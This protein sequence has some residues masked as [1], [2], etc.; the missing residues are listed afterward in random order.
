M[1]SSDLGS[2]EDRQVC[3][4]TVRMSLRQKRQLEE[5]VAHLGVSM[6]NYMLFVA[7]LEALRTGDSIRGRKPGWMRADL[8]SGDHTGD[9]GGQADKT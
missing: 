6:N 3:V 5:R 1:G 7:G 9:C 2:R 4:V 8:G